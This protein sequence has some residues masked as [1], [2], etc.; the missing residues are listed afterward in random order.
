MKQLAAAEAISAADTLL[1]TVPNQ[2]GV[3]YDAHAIESVLKYVAAELG[4]RR[5]TYTLCEARRTICEC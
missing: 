5:M 1:L 2:L 3:E 4:W